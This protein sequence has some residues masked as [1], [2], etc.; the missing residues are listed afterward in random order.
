MAIETL[1]GAK[2]LSKSPRQYKTKSKGAQEAHEA[3]RPSG[4]VFRSP[5]DSKLE[6]RELALYKLIWK[7]TLASQMAEALKSS[8]KA[9]FAVEDA[10]FSATGIRILFPGFIRAY[11]EGRDDPEVKLISTETWL[12]KLEVGQKLIPQE[13]VPVG[14]ETK[15][16]S[17][18]TEASLV[19][20]LEKLGI[21]R[22]STYAAIINTLFERAYIKKQGNT[23][24][25]TFIGFGVI[26]LLEK[27]FTNLIEYSFTSDME[28]TLDSIAMG[29][30]D[31]IKYLTQFYLG[32]TGLQ[33][34]V[35]K[36]AKLIKP[37]EA[38]TIIMPQIHS[39][40][41]IHVGK[42]G[43]YILCKSEDGSEEIHASLSEEIA[44][45]D[46][47][48]DDI[49]RLIEIQKDGPESL[50]TDQKS[51][52]AI[53]LLNGRYGP[54]FQLGEKSEDNP[55]PKRASVP[56][57]INPDTMSLED[58]SK[59]LHLPRLLGT[60]VETGKDVIANNGRFGPYVGHDGEFRSLKATDDLYTITLE[61]ALEILAEPKRGRG[62]AAVLKNFGKD[63]KDVTIAIYSGRY[64]AYIKY[65][66]KNIGLPKKY[67]K[68]NAYESLTLEQ[69][70]KIINEA[71]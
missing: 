36:Q 44:P 24:V 43:P 4:E 22:P 40:D 67:K 42:Y 29:K 33:S 13:I 28:N 11:V 3:I 46:L 37:D 5:V 18:F 14:H 57:G 2:Y 31:R 34:H 70:K 7:R 41:G 26:Q 32:K 15:A 23:I 60:H 65:G 64:G 35:E 30:V 27:N 56:K 10:A 50:G 9:V 63:D 49:K 45:A 39:V 48:D 68:D 12:P 71:T 47:I 1:Y 51:G 52:E 25:P 21:G 6:G 69:I 62:K 19:K 8:T 54:Y 38:R 59:L 58:I 17:R 20:E 53:Y 61:R 66:K 16:P 55:K